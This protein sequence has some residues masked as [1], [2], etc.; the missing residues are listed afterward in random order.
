MGWVGGKVQ[1]PLHEGKG[2]RGGWGAFGGWG[3]KFSR[4]YMKVKG[5][6]GGFGG[7]WERLGA[8]GGVGAGG[9]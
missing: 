5:G 6:L 7:L 3:E 8:L 9:P 2:F 1:P 4:L